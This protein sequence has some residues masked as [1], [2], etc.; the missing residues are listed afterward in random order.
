MHVVARNLAGL[1]RVVLTITSPIEITLL[2]SGIEGEQRLTAK[3]TDDSNKARIQTDKR[4][5]STKRPWQPRSASTARER[6]G[7]MTFG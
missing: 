3:R 1:F 5:S 2:Q 4:A 6:S 7:D